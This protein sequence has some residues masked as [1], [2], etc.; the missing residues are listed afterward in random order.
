MAD[1]NALSEG[2]NRVFRMQ[3]DLNIHRIGALMC[4]ERAHH[5]RITRTMRADWY[6]L[7]V[8][9]M[10]DVITVSA[11]ESPGMMAAKLP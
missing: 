8:L 6:R 5:V 11:T 2:I 7:S 9:A 3:F 1:T 10:P 4:S